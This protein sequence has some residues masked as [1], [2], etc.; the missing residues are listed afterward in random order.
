METFLSSDEGG[1]HHVENSSAQDPG[2]S[3]SLDF[4]L[5]KLGLECNHLVLICSL[6]LAC[7]CGTSYSTGRY[8]RFESIPMLANQDINVVMVD[9]AALCCS[10]L[11]SSCWT[12]LAHKSGRRV[13]LLHPLMF[14]TFMVVSAGFA[15]DYVMYLALVVVSYFGFSTGLVV[16]VTYLLEIS[17]RHKR[18]R[19]L[20][21]LLLV[22]TMASL[23]HVLAILL[24]PTL[25]SSWLT[26]S[27]FTL[28]AMSSVAYIGIFTVGAESPR[29]LA[30]R[31]RHLEAQQSLLSLYSGDQNLV[32]ALADCDFDSRVGPP[33]S[34]REMAWKTLDLIQ[35][36]PA[37]LIIPFT[38]TGQVTNPDFG[39]SILSQLFFRTACMFGYLVSAIVMNPPPLEADDDSEAAMNHPKPE[40]PK[41]LVATKI[42]LNADRRSRRPQPQTPMSQRENGYKGRVSSGVGGRHYDFHPRACLLA[43]Q[44]D[45]VFH[46]DC[47]LL[48]MRSLVVRNGGVGRAGR[49]VRCWESVCLFLSCFIRHSSAIC[50]LLGLGEYEPPSATIAT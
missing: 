14:G 35:L 21:L 33:H 6:G 49:L 11:G 16:G 44:V 42:R 10:L 26:L 41:H 40:I 36:L 47:G 30:R 5:D 32:R 4:F 34:R 1:S 45:L 46:A 31:G 7:T 22:T 39:V 23:L 8:F 19:A 37:C 43:R 3:V 17:P 50:H 12:F 15:T 20:F 29:W 28:A 9:V 48:L 24:T 27:D 13:A 2:G 25:D 38:G 18:A